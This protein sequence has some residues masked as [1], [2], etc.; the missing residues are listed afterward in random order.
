MAYNDTLPNKEYYSANDVLLTV[1]IEDGQPVKQLESLGAGIILAGWQPDGKGLLYWLNPGRGASAASDGL[2]LWSFQMDETM[3]RPLTT[4]LTNKEW[5]S[6]S[7]QG[8]LLTVEGGDRIVWSNKSLAVVNPNSGR[9]QHLANPKGCVAIDPCFSPD[10]KSIAY[11]A[12][13][14]L[15]EMFGALI[16]LMI[17]MLG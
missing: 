17:L 6:F 9:M 3:P 16:K 4:G 5:Q 8:Q 2:E 1:D 15:A 10:G 12:A 14:N 13:K 7:P 11:V